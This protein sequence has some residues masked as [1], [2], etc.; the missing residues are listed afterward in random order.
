MHRWPARS[1]SP[2]FQAL[3]SRARVY[4]GLTAAL[5]VIVLIVAAASWESPDLLKYSAFLLVAV[6]SSGMRLSVPGVA[7]TLP[8][9]FLFVLFGV[10]ELTQPETVVLGSVVTL[11]QCYW[12]QP[13]RPRLAKVIFNIASMAL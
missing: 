10:V 4:I 2:D 12:N 6:F 7:G 13:G 1:M 3:P 9:T 11:I 5:G 8:V